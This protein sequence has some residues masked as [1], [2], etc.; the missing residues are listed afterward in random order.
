VNGGVRLVALV[1]L[2]LIVPLGLR[3]LHPPD[4][5]EAPSY[6]P[7]LEGPRVRTP[8]E[9]GPVG[10]LRSMQ[11]AFVIIGDSMAGTRI[12][13]GHLTTLVQRPVAP[14]LQAGSGPVYWY[15]VLKNWVIASGTRPH[16]VFIFFRDTNLTNV[17]F[18]LDD[19]YR[20]MIDR[21][22]GERE[23]EVNAAI[24][25]ATAGP[26]HRAQSGIERVYGAD[27]ARAWI[28]PAI[29][30]PGRRRRTAFLSDMN[31]RF[32][33][34]HLA[35][36]EAADLQAAED[37]EADFGRYVDRSVL[38]LMVR[39]AKAAGL[40]LC[41]VRVQR[42]PVGGRPPNQSAALRRYVDDLQ[43]YV[44]SHGALWRDDTGDP[45][46]TLDMY[47]DGDHIDRS[48]R[49]RYTGIFFERMRSVL[50]PP[51]VRE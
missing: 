11:P 39:D 23:D 22:A 43:R 15:L 27:A 33:L 50:A 18:R 21:V 25:A 29:T 4:A 34:E 28:E 47:E 48:A 31:A 14:I 45:A 26:W 36:V 13:P 51:A 49:T 24:A 30:E 32:G 7:A 9:P 17:M 19:R 1:V 41:F 37:R 35:P 3:G 12:D 42:R 2:T 44:E 6:L 46:L 38:P 16:A 10:E 5:V 40:T 8:F 20:W